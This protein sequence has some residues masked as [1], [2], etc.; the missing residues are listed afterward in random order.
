MPC[1][2]QARES[3]TARLAHQSAAPKVPSTLPKAPKHPNRFSKQERRS[4]LPRFG[5]PLMNALRG[6]IA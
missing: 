3:S 1:E 5:H 4:Q 2:C 6:R